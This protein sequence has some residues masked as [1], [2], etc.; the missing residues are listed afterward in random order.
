MK[1]FIIALLIFVSVNSPYGA[2]IEHPTN[3]EADNS[4]MSKSEFFKRVDNDIYIIDKEAINNKA[5]ASGMTNS[6]WIDEKEEALF[7]T[8]EIDSKKKNADYDYEK[9]TLYKADFNNKIK[10]EYDLKKY[11]VVS[12]IFVVKGNTYV[13]YN[14]DYESYYLLCIDNKGKEKWDKQIKFEKDLK[15]IPEECKISLCTDGF[16]VAFSSYDFPADES[17]VENRNIYIQ[18]YDFNGSSMWGKKISQNKNNEGYYTSFSLYSNDKNI[19]LSYSTYNYEDEK[20]AMYP[21]SNFSSKEIIS[22][23]AKG[24]IKKSITMEVTEDSYSSDMYMHNNSLYVISKDNK[25]IK[26]DNDLKNIAEVELPKAG[27]YSQLVPCKMGLYFVYE[28]PVLN[29]TTSKKFDYDLKPLE[30]KNSLASS[31]SS[32][33]DINYLGEIDGKTILVEGNYY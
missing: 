12:N 4:A 27:Y 2:N 3:F 8:R 25:L 29:N 7:Y 20:G 11:D 15:T 17:V 31:F 26:L 28:T 30:S 22:L 6:A 16:V 18:K 21:S 33:A 5:K 32:Y 13:F 19:Y 24:N 14:H 10:W 9:T 23:D 1:N